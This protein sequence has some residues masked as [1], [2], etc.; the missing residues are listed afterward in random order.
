MRPDR[1]PLDFVIGITFGAETQGGVTDTRLLWQSG[2][3]FLPD[4]LADVHSRVQPTAHEVEN[5]AE[6]PTK[7]GIGGI[8]QLVRAQL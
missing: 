2:V 5:M 1:E 8:A 3:I 4:G 6:N 7:V